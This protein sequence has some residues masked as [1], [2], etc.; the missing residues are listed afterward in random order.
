MLIAELAN[1]G[2]YHARFMHKQRRHHHILQRHMLARGNGLDQ[3]LGGHDAHN[4]VDRALIDGNTGVLHQLV[5]Q[6]RHT[7]VQIDGQ[8]IHAGRKHLHGHGIGDFDGGFDQ[9][10]LFFGEN[11]LIL[12]VVQQLHQFLGG[13]VGRFFLGRPQGRQ[14]ANQ[15]FHH[16]HNGRKDLHDHLKRIGKQASQGIGHAGGHDLGQGFAK[17]QQQRCNDRRSNG[18]AVF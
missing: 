6:L 16:K 12:N 2:G 17:E 18:R 1:D 3:L 5:R 4:V 11:A 10:A 15:L 8:Q 9:F 7:V 14:L 13:H